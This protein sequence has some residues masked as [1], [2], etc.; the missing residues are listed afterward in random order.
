MNDW[1]NRFEDDEHTCVIVRCTAVFM[2][3]ES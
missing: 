2:S 1:H 3:V